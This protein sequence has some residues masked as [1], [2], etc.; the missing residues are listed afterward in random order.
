MEIETNHKE[1]HSSEL[2]QELTGQI[3][4]YFTDNADRYY[5]ADW[6]DPYSVFFPNPEINE[7][8]QWISSVVR[9]S[10]S[11]ENGWEG[12]QMVGCPK[13]FPIYGD[14][15]GAWAPL[16]SRGTREEIIFNCDIPM[17][18]SNIEVFETNEYNKVWL[19]LR[20]LY[21]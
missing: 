13:V 7:Y 2:Q 15:K 14:I 6:S 8:R 3:H 17:Y 11:Y 1:P 12:Y 21:Y 10:S 16:R 4:T 20:L 19:I 9:L 5:N 18:I